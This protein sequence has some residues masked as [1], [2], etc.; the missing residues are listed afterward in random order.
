[1]CQYCDQD[2]LEEFNTDNLK[3]TPKYGHAWINKDFDLYEINFELDDVI[4]C[5]SFEINYCPICGR[6]LK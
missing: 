6:K 2:K 5:A 4:H 1:M 3:V